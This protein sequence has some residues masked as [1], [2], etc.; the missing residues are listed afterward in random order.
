[1]TAKVTRYTVCIITSKITCLNKAKIQWYLLCN[2][3]D[4]IE[5]VTCVFYAPTCTEYFP[6]YADFCNLFTCFYITRLSPVQDNIVL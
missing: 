5:L 1:M 3:G 6:H 4:A 2:S